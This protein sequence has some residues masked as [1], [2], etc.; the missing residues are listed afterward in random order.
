[1]NELYD[2]L[3]VTHEGKII[4]ILRRDTV[5]Q[6][7]NTDKTVNE[8][9]TYLSGIMSIKSKDNFHE[10]IL[11]L[12]NNEFVIVFDPSLGEI[13]GLLHYTDLNKQAVRIYCYLWL[14]A[15]EM[16]MAEILGNHCNSIDDW[17][18]H[19]DEHRQVTV[20]GR[21]EYEKRKNIR[22]SAIEG[23]ELSDLSRIFGK[24][25][26]L[27]HSMNISK[28]KYDKM[29]GHVI[30]LRNYVMHPV[31]ILIREHADVHKVFTRIDDLRTLVNAIRVMNKWDK[32][33]K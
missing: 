5:E 6:C 2:Q 10:S 1:M 27:L 21:C 33:K 31:R 7:E 25:P 28:T 15:L 18:G 19:L 22:L 32:V 4:G 23:V 11:R 26:K 9:T 29:I 30:H 13:C 12:G 20:L 24:M 8:Y 17:I 3:P 16:G 14:S